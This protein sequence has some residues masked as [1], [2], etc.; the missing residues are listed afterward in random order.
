[1]HS[2]PYDIDRYRL[3]LFCLMPKTN[4]SSCTVTEDND[5][6]YIY[7]PSNQQKWYVFIKYN[8]KWSIEIFLY[9]VHM[10]NLIFPRLNKTFIRGLV[11]RAV[12]EL[13]VVE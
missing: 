13:P 1:M 7:K 12:V 4:Y 2:S 10:W 5:F 8:L 9:Q 11:S 3:D 6:G